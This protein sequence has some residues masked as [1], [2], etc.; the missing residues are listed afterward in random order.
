MIGWLI[1]DI[2]ILI[3]FPDAFVVSGNRRDLGKR[4]ERFTGHIERANETIALPANEQAGKQAKM[5]WQQ[6]VILFHPYKQDGIGGQPFN[7]FLLQ[8]H[9]PSP[10]RIVLMSSS[11]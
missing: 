10:S 5:G 6:P 3:Q 4:H 9:L 11:L 1:A 2:T 7:N 8:L